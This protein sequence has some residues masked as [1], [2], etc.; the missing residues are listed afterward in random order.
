MH[1]R[2]SGGATTLEFSAFGR[3]FRLRLSNNARLEKFAAGSSLQLYKGTLEGVP[4]SWARISIHDGLPR[5]MIWDGRELFVVDAAADAVNY[6][7]A[8]T[9]MFKLSDA[10]TGAGRFFQWRCGEGAARPGRRL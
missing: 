4:D 1:T 3:F 6:G 9:V 5:G 7:S 10:V 2:R 8:G